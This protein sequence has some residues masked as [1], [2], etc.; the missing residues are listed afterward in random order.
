MKISK[1]ID[2]K[3]K[4]MI[5]N[6]DIYTKVKVKRGVKM[7][8]ESQ[9][10]FE[11][12][13]KVNYIT[14]IGICLLMSLTT[15]SMNNLEINIDELFPFIIV[16]I[17]STAIYFF[18]IKDTIKA[19]SF[20][21]IIILSNVGYLVLG[22]FNE[23]TVAADILVFVAGIIC[24]ALYFNKKL[25]IIN[26]M[27]LDICIIIIFF[28]NPSSILS[29]KFSIS[30]MLNFFA[31]LN[32]VIILIYFLTIWGGKLIESANKKSLESRELIEKLN[33]ILINIKENTTNLDDNIDVFSKD[34]ILVNT[35]SNNINVNMSEIN[36]GVQNIAHSISGINLG[37]SK[38]SSSLDEVRNISNK[39]Y[40]TSNDMRKNVIS[41]AKEIKSM[42]D[43]MRMIKSSVNVSLETVNVLKGS[44][45]KINNE[46]NNIYEISEQT[47]L[48]A[49]NASIEAARAGE[50]G[51]G[52][53]IVAEEVK[54]LAEETNNIVKNI[55]DIITEI[56]NSTKDAVVK[57]ADGNVSA[58]TGIKVVNNVHDAFSEIEDYFEII[59]KYI[60]EEHEFIENVINN[61]NPM[62]SE[63]EGIGNI[64]EEHL[65][66]TGE[67]EKLINEQGEKINSM[68][69]SIDEIKLLSKNLKELSS[70]R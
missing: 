59:S 41:G 20:S 55:Y 67:I 19:M 23:K 64:T 62:K 36:N 33:L 61:F 13:H 44:I 63:I 38:S 27:I 14:I 50:Y 47:N 46:I 11:K 54:K 7:E 17:L 68:T 2:F 8:K 31:I 42:N 70:S 15:I 12:I 5:K 65:V 9:F 6:V 57:V 21:C 53:S 48:L 4:V 35:N 26:A 16:S 40:E 69:L 58:E 18:K 60:Y 10:S 30:S 24:S 28:I 32:G 49:L 51:K 34:I 39:I 45:D 52:F 3:L 29:E 37:I 22:S 43:T 56:N 66:S 1:N 25:L